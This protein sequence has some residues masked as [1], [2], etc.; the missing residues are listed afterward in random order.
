MM[1]VLVDRFAS[2]SGLGCHME[3]LKINVAMQIWSAYWK[4]CM[5]LKLGLQLGVS[6]LG[7]FCLTSSPLLICHSVAS[8]GPSQPLLIYQH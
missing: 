4:I 8:L 7:G 1:G 6:R 3:P 5:Y 2:Y